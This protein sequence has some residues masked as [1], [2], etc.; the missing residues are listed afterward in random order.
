MPDDSDFISKDE[1]ERREAAWEH[2]AQEKGYHCARCGS[3]PPYGER[4]VFFER[5]LCGWC[6]HMMDKD[7]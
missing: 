5:G 3:I 6:A 2:V 4:E 7:D 1:L